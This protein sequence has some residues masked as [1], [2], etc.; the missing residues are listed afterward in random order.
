M[1]EGFVTLI[2]TLV[3]VGVLLWAA[4]KLL[5]LL[6]LEPRYATAVTVLMQVFAVL[7]LLSALLQVFGLYDVGLPGLRSLKR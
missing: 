4:T 2:V 5:G 3:V 1:I 7:I 6:P